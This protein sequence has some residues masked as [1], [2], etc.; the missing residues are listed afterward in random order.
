MITFIPNIISAYCFMWA[1]AKQIK[2]LANAQLL[3]P[4]LLKQREGESN[5][6]TRAIVATV[7]F[8]L[9]CLLLK[10]GVALGVEGVRSITLM[11]TLMAIQ[12]ISVCLVCLSV[13]VAFV[14]F[15]TQ[16]HGASDDT[17]KNPFGRAGAVCGALIFL[18]VI[19]SMPWAHSALPYNTYHY[20]ETSEVDVAFVCIGIFLAVMSV[21]YYFVAMRAQ[22]ITKAE[23]DALMGI[24][25]IRSK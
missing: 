24:Y 7:V 14:V 13:L 1:S 2:S 23:M 4:Q 10:S 18:F 6:P 22:T 5:T 9:G 19:V 8:G 17:F 16:G 11:R 12:D 25:A 21:Y 15:R 20:L 3:F